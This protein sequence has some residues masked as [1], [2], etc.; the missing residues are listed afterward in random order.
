[1]SNSKTIRVGVFIIILMHSDFLCSQIHSFYD[2]FHASYT[3][4]CNTANVA[5][6][7]DIYCNDDPWVIAFEDHFNGPELDTKKWTPITG[8]VR[9]IEY[10]GSKQWFKP[11][12]IVHSNGVVEIVA[13][14]ENLTN[15][16]YW[17]WVTDHME[18]HCSD[19]KYTSGEFWSKYKFGYGYYKIRCRLPK[20]KGFFPAYWTYS[21]PW[22]EIDVFEFWNEDDEED[23][24]S[25]IHTNCH[26]VG[27]GYHYA[28]GKTHDFG[29]D[30]SEEFHEFGLNYAEDRIEWY[31]DEQ[32]IRID[33]RYSTMLGQPVS[34]FIEQGKILQSKLYLPEKALMQ[35]LFTLSI[36]NN[37]D[38]PDNLIS[39]KNNFEIDYFKFFKRM[40][41]SPIYLHSQGELGIINGNY[42]FMAAELIEVDGSSIY[43][44]SEDQLEMV[45]N[46]YIDL[47]PGFYS[48]EGSDFLARIDEVCPR[49]KSQINSLDN[50]IPTSTSTIIH[51]DKISCSLK[52]PM[53]NGN[54]FLIFKGQ[55]NEN[56]KINLLDILGKRYTLNTFQKNES[57]FVDIKSLKPGIYFVDYTNLSDNCANSMKFVIF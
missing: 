17:I 32:L 53:L 4:S 47:K 30:Y 25:I 43:L 24:S 10:E 46:D 22:K 1:M 12:N 9:D 45:A 14:E 54:D 2:V 50:N 44:W 52:T 19:F 42:N 26:I 51:E 3:G 5:I 34:C 56:L 15:Q 49:D 36:Q 11:E 16:C 7:S 27:D 55:R 28:C 18:Q 21:D 20:G 39:S 6:S 57:V 29:V 48:V 33:Y 38:A 37:D 31:V 13:R 23:Y 35:V 40:D 8:V 41:C